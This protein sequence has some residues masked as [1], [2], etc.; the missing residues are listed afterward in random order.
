MLIFGPASLAPKRREPFTNEMFDSLVNLPASSNLG[1]IGKFDCQSILGKSLI[2]AIA[3]SS[4]AGFRKAEMFQSNA[5]TFYLMWS[6]MS[7]NFGGSPDGSVAD[8]SDEQLMA[9]NEG[10]YLVNTPPQQV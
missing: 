3:V 2:A 7:W 6:L 4:S 9:L 1:S 10:D 5:E 8:P